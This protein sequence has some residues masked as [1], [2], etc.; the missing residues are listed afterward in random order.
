VF[1]PR[2]TVYSGYAGYRPSIGRTGATYILGTINKFLTTGRPVQGTL[3]FEAETHVVFKAEQD[4]YIGE[5]FAIAYNSIAY[6]RVVTSHVRSLLGLLLWKRYYDLHVAFDDD[7]GERQHVII[8]LGKDVVVPIR[9]AIE[10][11][12]RSEPV[13]ETETA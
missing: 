13:V 1:Q 8:G 2:R 5:T 4:P 7:A 12:V 6:A 11:R 9:T 10:G 3:D